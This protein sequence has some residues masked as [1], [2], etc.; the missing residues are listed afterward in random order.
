MNVQR[1]YYH[2][3][4]TKLG[5]DVSTKTTSNNFSASLTGVYAKCSL[6]SSTPRV[7]AHTKSSVQPKIMSP[8]TNHSSQRR[9][10]VSSLSIIPK[11]KIPKIVVLPSIDKDIAVASAKQVSGKIPVATT[12]VA[13][14]TKETPK[15]EKGSQSQARY[16]S[17]LHTSLSTEWKK[18]DS[19]DKENSDDNE[20]APRRTSSLEIECNY[21]GRNTPRS[22][23]TARSSSH[24]IRVG[25]KNI[26]Q[27]RNQ[28]RGENKSSDLL[29]RKNVKEVAEMD[30][31]N[32][33]IQYTPLRKS[34]T[35]KNAVTDGNRLGPSRPSANVITTRY[36]DNESQRLRPRMLPKSRFRVKIQ[37]CRHKSVNISDS[38]NVVRDKRGKPLEKASR[39]VVIQDK[40]TQ[41]SIS[42]QKPKLL[43]A[44]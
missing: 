37:R 21:T 7:A 34:F 4:T 32:V 31:H 10:H 41:R 9:K 20:K 13:K 12:A 38:F 2:V 30:A 35:I 15:S 29:N 8:V 28:P 22:A 6:S 44:R 26:S 43:S 1:G 36:K 16:V 19:L 3:S 42:I 40:S 25:D 5:R 11:E 18:T 27:I 24:E 17:C 39:S 23:A 33:R 14:T